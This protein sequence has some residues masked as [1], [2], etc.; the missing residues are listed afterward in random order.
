[1]RRQTAGRSD[2][3]PADGEKKGLKEALAREVAA[4]IEA[5]IGA[6]AADEIDFEALETAAR[7]QALRLAARALERR[8]NEDRGDR[9]GPHLPCPACAGPAE[10]QG[11]RAKTF[12]TALGEMTLER[13]YYHC[14]ACESGFYPRDRAL[15]L[16][17][18]SLSPAVTRMVGLTA[19]MVSFAESENLLWELAGAR[20]EAK[21]VERAAEALG[22]EIAADEREFVEPPPAEEIAPTLYLG[23]DGTGVPMR[24]DETKGRKGKQ[25][26]GSSKSREAKLCVSFSAESRDQEGRPV[27]D[28]GSAAYNAGIESAACR[29]TDDELSEFARRVAREAARS[30]FDRAQ[31]QAALGDGASWIWNLFGEQFPDAIQIVDNG[32]VKQHLTQAAKAIYGPTSDLARPFYKRLHDLLDDGKLDEIIGALREKGGAREEVR[33]CLEYLEKNRMRMDYPRFRALGLCVTTG[34][35]EAGCKTAIGA[36]LKRGGM[37]W[38]VPGANA[39]IALRCCILS[40][41]F[42]DFWERRAAAR[43]AAI[44]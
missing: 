29:D 33:Q 3:S 44:G 42:A 12:V 18:G 40:G 34:V 22:R 9:A 27:R 6:G 11:R 35:I 41:R 37:H 7:R 15:G 31:R 30:G 28:E 5:L 16:A 24:P 14:A 36:R 32:H 23:L 4:E 21:Q 26:D 19:S 25:P 2:G 20:V 39:I 1:M 17:D 8:L 10:Y 13:A 43:Q 38:S